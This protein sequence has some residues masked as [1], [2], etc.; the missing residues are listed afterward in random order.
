MRSGS[1]PGMQDIE[2][3]SGKRDDGERPL[4]KQVTFATAFR[5][6]RALRELDPAALMRQ[7]PMGDRTQLS[8]R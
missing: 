4:V 1:P 7:Q 6:T 2:D 8:P 5:R 3:G